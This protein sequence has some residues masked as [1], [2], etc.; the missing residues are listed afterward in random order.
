[1]YF[2]IY[3]KE[4]KHRILRRRRRPDERIK[5][6]KNNTS[7]VKNERKKESTGTK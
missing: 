6:H 2:Q 1:M 5:A 3:E 7:E 4:E